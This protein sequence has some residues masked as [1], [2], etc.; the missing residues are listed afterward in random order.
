MRKHLSILLALTF[1]LFIQANAQYFQA[2]LVI[3]V[4]DPSAAKLRFKLKPVGGDLTNFQFDGIEIFVRKP[5]ADDATTFG[6]I[7]DNTSDFPGLDVTKGG[8]NADF[9]NGY[10]TDDDPSYTIYYFY[11]KSVGATTG[12]KDY[13]NG[14]EYELFNVAINANGSSNFE[15]AA[16]NVISLPYYLTLSRKSDPGGQPDYTAT[17]SHGAA[18]NLLFYG[19]GAIKVGS[20]DF[21]KPP[22][23]TPVKF[24][25]FYAQK[26][27][28]AAKLTWTV[29][30]DANNKNF[31]V[32]RSLDGHSYKVFTT[33]DALANGNAVNTYTTTDPVLSKQGS[34]NIYY[35]V[36][37]VDKN[38]ASVYSVIRLL[39]VDNA[40]PLALYPNPARTITRLVVD[41][42]EA[43]K[44]AI[45]VRDA[46]GRQVQ[47]INTTLVKGIN[48]K[49]IN[50]SALPGGDY[51][52]NL[53]SEKSSQSIK[54]T[55]IN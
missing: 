15:F 21:Q 52:V 43:T 50:V 27:G 18:S 34:K 35:R 37:Q 49:D 53:V 39:N 11:G 25:S 9:V 7:T 23:L 19:P 41:A 14:V 33:V 32:E 4:T 10:G 55:K 42:P 44:A 8:G 38:G 45:I 51:N 47:L 1:A 29:N 20:K 40:T 17:S 22:Q 24:L 46:A 31:N 30:D 36:Q 28:D 26:S 16:D 48:Q 2:S 12:P 3:D 5:T 54:L 13:L 6:T